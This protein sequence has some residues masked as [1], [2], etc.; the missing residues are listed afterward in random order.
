M[1]ARTRYAVTR[2]VG[3]VMV[4]VVCRFDAHAHTHTYKDRRTPLSVTLFFPP[5][6][7]FSSHVKKRALSRSNTSLLT[8][9]M[10]EVHKARTTSARNTTTATRRGVTSLRSPG[11]SLSSAVTHHL[12]CGAWRTNVTEFARKSGP[13]M[14]EDDRTSAN[15][16][17]R[18]KFECVLIIR[19]TCFFF[20]LCNK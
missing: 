9:A 6:D 1:Y 14:N 20:F 7:R 16:S 18:G 2:R 15:R 10:A 17:R 11:R 13:E 12:T 3:I 5:V 19:E 8:L 4:M